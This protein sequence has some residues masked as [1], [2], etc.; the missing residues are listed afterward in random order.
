MTSPTPLPLRLPTCPH[1]RQFCLNSRLQTVSSSASHPLASFPRGDAL[2]CGRVGRQS[3]VILGANCKRFSATG[4]A[5]SA[6]RQAHGHGDSGRSRTPRS[7]LRLGINTRA[8]AALSSRVCRECSHPL[9]VKAQLL[10]SLGTESGCLLPTPP[11]APPRLLW[12]VCHCHEDLL[13]TR[14]RPCALL[15]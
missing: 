4:E 13:Q 7:A 1:R 2:R 9:D 6:Q 8:A 10:G 14:K 3:R 12:E 15:M 11:S 5:A